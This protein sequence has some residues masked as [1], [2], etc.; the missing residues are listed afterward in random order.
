MLQEDVAQSY[1]VFPQ[2]SFKV[3]C[4]LQSISYAA[5][6]QHVDEHAIRWAEHSVAPHS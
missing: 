2:K 1:P 4:D 6:M 3:L 5:H